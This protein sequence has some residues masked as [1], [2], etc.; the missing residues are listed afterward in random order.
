MG[1]ADGIFLGEKEGNWLFGASRRIKIFEKKESWLVR[2]LV[3]G[4]WFPKPV[5]R[6]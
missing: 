6:F 1:L 4:I 5:A 3:D 2:A